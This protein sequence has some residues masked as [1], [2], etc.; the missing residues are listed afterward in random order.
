MTLFSVHL[1]TGQQGSADIWRTDQ[2]FLNMAMMIVF[3]W[4]RIAILRDVELNFLTFSALSSV[5]V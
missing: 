4:W 3:P 2:L 1:P 5:A